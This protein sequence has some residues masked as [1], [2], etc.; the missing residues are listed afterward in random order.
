MGRTPVDLQTQKGN[1]QVFSAT[2]NSER[3]VW[4]ET[5]EVHKRTAPALNTKNVDRR[6]GQ[7]GFTLSAVFRVVNEDPG[8]EIWSVQVPPIVGIPC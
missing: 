5:E 7:R 3:E 2:A 1:D 8:L 4:S 6:R